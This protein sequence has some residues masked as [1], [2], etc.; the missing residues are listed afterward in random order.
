MTAAVGRGKI[1]AVPHLTASATMALLLRSAWLLP[2]LLIGTGCLKSATS[3]PS[4][5]VATDMT[6]STP[7]DQAPKVEWTDATKGKWLELGPVRMTV[8]GVEVSKPKAAFGGNAKDDLLQVT[9][10]LKNVD[11]K[12][13]IPY[14]PWHFGLIPK[15]KLKDDLGN[16]YK[17]VEAIGDFKGQASGQPSL[18]SDDNGVTDLLVFERPLQTASHLLLELDGENV[19]QSGA[20]RWRI[21]ASMWKTK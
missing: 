18:R 12:K 14:T 6:T 4:A 5:P 21:P 7:L 17:M 3:K 13:I 19:G 8:E 2:L 20:F 16:E 9:V 1:A 10:R 15:C 11:Q